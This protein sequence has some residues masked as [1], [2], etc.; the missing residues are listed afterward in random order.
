MILP[1]SGGKSR[2]KKREIKKPGGRE[3]PT[4]LPH[5][6]DL[7]LEQ[8]SYLVSFPVAII[9]YSVKSNLRHSWLN[10]LTISSCSLSR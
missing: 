8:S 3:T 7:Q 2:G 9:K 5:Q 1:R 10:R 4:T 6:G